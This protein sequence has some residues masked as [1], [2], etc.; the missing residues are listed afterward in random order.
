[1]GRIDQLKQPMKPDGGD[2][3]A[4]RLAAPR[5]LIET[6]V[7]STSAS[8]IDIDE[9][10]R[11]IDVR[12]ASPRGFC[13]GVERAI[14]IVED[15][16]AAY[17][18]P[19]YVRHEIVHNAHV[20]GRLRRMGAVFVEDLK[21]APSDRPVIVSAHGA[22]RSVYLEA[23][24][25]EMTLIDAT[26]PLVLKVHNEARRH[27]ALGRHV[28]LIGHADHPEIIG[29]IGQ[30]PQGAVSLIET[31]DDAQAF[32]PPAAAVEG[33]LA[34]AT[35]T[36]LSVDETRDI[37]EALKARFPNIVGPSRADICYATTN[38][39][40]AVKAIAP[41]CDV[42][43][44]VG[45][46]TSSNSMRLVETARASGARRAALVS[47][48]ATFDAAELLDADVIG[49][50]AGA[51]VPEELVED[52]LATIANARVLRVKAIEIVDEDVAFKQPAMPPL[53]A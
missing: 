44:V 19:V 4:L 27:A 40:A 15:A 43:L 16:L 47:E 12:L 45:D 1:M 8:A 52:L 32:H 6:S 30:A 51:S 7:S 23:G 36:T 41:D 18:A 29:V 33:G 17:G 49:V 11:P 42:F 20:V 10:L 48:P 24:Q 39:Q 25:R 22:P 5:A 46:A 26:C 14:R 13:A 53:R 38:R 9:R 2:A 37:V 50:S 21:D 31:L 28:A 3:P 35:Q 34:Y